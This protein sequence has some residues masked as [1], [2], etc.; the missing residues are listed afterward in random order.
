MSPVHPVSRPIPPDVDSAESLALA[1]RRV[2]R[3]SAVPGILEILCQNTNMGF[4]AVA[5]VTDGT[6]TACAVRD[7]I[8][9]GLKPG[10]QLDVHTTLCKEARA[11]LRPVAFDHA[12]EDPKYKDHH[13]P[14]LY[15]IES[16]VSVPIVL[17]GGEYFGNLCAIDPHPAHVAN[18]AVLAAFTSFAQLIAVEL[19]REIQLDKLE[20]AL[21]DERAVSLLREQF[22][23]VLG[24]DLRS[25]LSAVASTA[26]LMVIRPD[27]V[28][29]KAT[30][31]RIKSSVGRMSRLIEDVLDFARGRLG[32]GIP[33]NMKT[34]DGLAAA[35]LEVVFEARESHPGFVI[36]EHIDIPF[37]TICDH[38]RMQ[39]LLSN[40]L[41]NALH[42]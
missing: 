25:P 35:L 22:I 39:Q 27:A 26:E 40:L 32:G 24:H 41:S 34:G 3:I 42:H 9:F 17:A 4:A 12:S 28:D 23:A 33:L 36:E 11:A 20:T 31:W 37:P 5:R 18:E 6:W 19:E 29:V 8:G 30:G 2:G 21:L 7:G 16:Y 38:T 13:T 1:V 10:G 14:R 15:K